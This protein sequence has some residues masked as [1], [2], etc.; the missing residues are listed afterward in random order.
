[1]L[2]V[3]ENGQFMAIGFDRGG[4]SLYRGDIGRDRSKTLKTLSSGTSSV[5]GIAFKQ[6]GKV[7]NKNKKFIIL[8]FLL[9]ISILFYLGD[10]YV[11]LFRFWSF[12]I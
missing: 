2:A 5:T 6:H 10:S 8:S 1:M 4:I 9:F 11:R 3:T 7:K 12:S